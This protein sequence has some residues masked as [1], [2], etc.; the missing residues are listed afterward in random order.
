MARL[1]VTF[2]RIDSSKVYDAPVAKGSDIRTEIVTMPGNTAMVAEAG[3]EIVELTADEDCWVA[4]GTDP[5]GVTTEGSGDSRLIKAGIP[6][7]FSIAAGESVS[8]VS[9]EAA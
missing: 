1:V 5:E 9:D 3:E 2:S 7:T 4:I 8:V 6:Y